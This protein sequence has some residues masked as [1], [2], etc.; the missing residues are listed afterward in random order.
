M[1]AVT[2]ITGGESQMATLA[3]LIVKMF[4]FVLGDAVTWT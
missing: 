4:S 3:I 2:E 1:P